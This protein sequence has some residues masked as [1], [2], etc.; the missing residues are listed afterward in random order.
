MAPKMRLCILALALSGATVAGFR[1]KAASPTRLYAMSN[2]D[3]KKS[4]GIGAFSGFPSQVLA[5]KLRIPLLKS[6]VAVRVAFAW[7]PGR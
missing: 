1:P 3:A 6:V 5:A 7:R 4:L 2:A